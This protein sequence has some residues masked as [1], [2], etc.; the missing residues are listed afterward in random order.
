MKH[1]ILRYSLF[2]LLSFPVYLTVSGQGTIPV[3]E[4]AQENIKAKG[5]AVDQSMIKL[6]WAPASPK[7]WL[8]G[9]NYGYSIER[10]TVMTNNKWQA[11]GAKTVLNPSLK[12][13][14]L[15][16]WEEYALRSDYAAVIAQAFY[17]EDFELNAKANDIGSIINRSSELEQRFAT[18]VFMAEYDYKAAELAGW[19]FTDNTTKENEKYLYRVILNRPVKQAGDTAAVFIG[20]SDREDL[21]PPM[22][23]RAKWGDK[24]VML[25]W[26]YELR[27]REYHSYHVEKKSSETNGEFVRITGLPVTVLDAD[28]Q[29]AF[30]I[31]TLQ[32]NETEYSYRIIGLTSFG[33][34]SPASAIVSGHGEKQVS[35]IP[36]IYAGEFTSES[37]AE[38]YWE[39]ECEEIDVID[40]LQL[41]K[42]DKI[43]GEYFLFTDNIDKRQK[44]LQFKMEEPLVYLK[45]LAVNKNNTRSESFPFRLQKTDS[46]PPA[47]PTGLQ[48]AIDSLGVARLAWK[49]NEETDLQGYRIL[50]SFADKNE[51]SVLTPQFIKENQYSDTLSL[52][53]M[54]GKVYYSLTALD[55]RYNESA[56]CEEIAAVKP[57]NRTLFTPFFTKHEVAD[58][59]AVL[60][61]TVN[62]SDS[63][64]I[65]T[66]E[67]TTVNSANTEILYTG[68][69]SAN[70]Y[71]DEP[72][73]TGTYEYIISVRDRQG[74]ISVTPVPLELY[75][76]TGGNSNKVSGFNAYVNEKDGY[77]EL[78][79][80]KHSKALL[81]R[82]YKAGEDKP[83]ALWKEVEPNIDRIAD[84]QVSPGTKYTYTILFTTQADG[85]S[86][87]SS[88]SADY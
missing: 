49:A 46:V 31:D 34:E 56:P 37:D 16:G 55:V 39:F 48:V 59:K 18:S 85:L 52:N 41:V 26:N 21:P 86:K 7:A 4:E 51:K 23:P 22:E 9:R 71:I 17:G 67:R 60:E 6:R 1:H 61:W 77:I 78:S 30:H 73:T 65:Y 54:N 58:G 38:I 64:L 45:L 20:F 10:Y 2:L 76:K 74:R 66:L 75:I 32:N 11:T 82:I 57:N 88:V 43:D 28:M 42:S 24:S 19:A 72:G 29:D 8:D 62:P 44:Q 84:E 69:N 83:A 5:R 27:A 36:Q 3:Q 80:K 68:G 70:R 63:S 81:Y 87:T 47:I 13:T 35:C 15:A 40:R 53:L 25:S 12:V 79:W 33:E 14:P 50:R